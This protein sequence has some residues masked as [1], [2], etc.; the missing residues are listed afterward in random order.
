M[1]DQI[2]G[3]AIQIIDEQLP[4]GMTLFEN[5]ESESQNDPYYYNWLFPH[6]TNIGDFGT[7]MTS[8]QYQAVLE[9]E[10]SL[11]GLDYVIQNFELS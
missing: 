6:A 1:E 4:E 11:K 5:Y 2:L 8:D 7:G 10:K 9:F 3:N